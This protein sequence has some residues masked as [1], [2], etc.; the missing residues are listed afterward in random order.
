MS[1]LTM[2]SL[3]LL[4]LGAILVVID[5]YGYWASLQPM[6]CRLCPPIEYHVPNILTFFELLFL[7]MGV[8][9][10]YADYEQKKA[11]ARMLRDN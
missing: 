3:G 9:V 5:I 11:S 8:V 2:I 10:K 7:G 1:K 4:A 6:G